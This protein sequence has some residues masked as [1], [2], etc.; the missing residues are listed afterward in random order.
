MRSR[1]WSAT[2]PACGEA[3]AT[4][5]TFVRTVRRRSAAGRQGTPPY[6]RGRH[7]PG[8]EAVIRLIGAVLAEQNDECT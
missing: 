5:V 8:R 2:C 7:L 3:T 6:R 4:S 1:I